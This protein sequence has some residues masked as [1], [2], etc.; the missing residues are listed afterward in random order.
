MSEKKDARDFNFSASALSFR[1]DMRLPKMIDSPVIIP[2][3]TM[4]AVKQLA[5]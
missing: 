3:V 4:Q 2:P 5:W 1:V